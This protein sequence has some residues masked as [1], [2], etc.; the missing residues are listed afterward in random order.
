MVRLSQLLVVHITFGVEF[1]EQ[2][3]LVFYESLQCGMVKITNVYDMPP[4]LMI[5][6]LF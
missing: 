1:D 4:R 3:A 6:I 2:E 5:N